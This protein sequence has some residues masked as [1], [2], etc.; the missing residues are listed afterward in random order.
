MPQTGFF[1]TTSLTFSTMYSRAAGSPGPLARNTASGS[2]W[3][4][5]CCR[6]VAGMERHARPALHEVAD[7]RRLDARVDRSDERPVARRPRRARPPASTSR[8][9]RGRPSTARRR[10][11]RAPRARRSAP[12]KT[13]PRIEPALRMCRTSARV[14][15]PVIA[16]DRRSRAASRASRASAPGASSWLTAS[17]MIAARA[18]TRS[19]SIASARDAVVAD[20]RIGEGDELAGEARVGHRLLVAGHAGREDDLADRVAVVADVRRRRTA[21]RPRAGRSAPLT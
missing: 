18:W 4:S 21:C 15:T 19:D 5:V 7:D 2:L 11:A 10:S 17:R 13:P 6:D 3:S 14:S 1:P 9:G 20:V 16:R 8:P 12:G